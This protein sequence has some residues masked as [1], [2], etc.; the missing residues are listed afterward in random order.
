MTTSGE[1]DAYFRGALDA[2]D[3]ISFDCKGQLPVE[4]QFRIEAAYASLL[5]QRLAEVVR[6]RMEP[7]G[8]IQLI[9]Q[10]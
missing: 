2:L 7:C 9:K 5:E 10:V 4:V 3:L 1:K 6:P 8:Q